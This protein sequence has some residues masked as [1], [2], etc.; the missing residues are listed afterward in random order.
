MILNQLTKNVANYLDHVENQIV[1]Y[2]NINTIKNRNCALKYI[3]MLSDE[4]DINPINI[5]RRTALEIKTDT[6]KNLIGLMGID[7]KEEK[8]KFKT[9]RKM[10]KTTNRSMSTITSEECR[11]FGNL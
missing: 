9:N 4:A 3:H 1:C 10:A 2:K 8:N 7:A 6:L 11:A 5:S